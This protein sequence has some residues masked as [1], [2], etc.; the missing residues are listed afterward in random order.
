MATHRIAQNDQQEDREAWTQDATTQPVMA[1]PAFM[2]VVDR[3]V[4]ATPTRSYY[5]TRWDFVNNL[6]ERVEHVTHGRAGVIQRL[7]TYLLVGGFAALVNLTVFGVMLRLP[8]ATNEQVHN[9]IA[10]VIAAETSIMANFIPNDRITFSHLPGHSRSW[11]KRCT[12][13]H[14][15]SITGTILTF[16]IEYALTFAFRL[17]G[18][19]AETQALGAE[20]V[21]IIIV[22]FY[23][24][25]AHHLFTYR[26][27]H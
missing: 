3:P 9:I 8:L 23:N 19:G 17:P 13:F 5:L 12:R 25:T 18:V 21:A 27:A 22:L 20:A 1:A 10:Y 15:T 2:P 24:F 16:I 4:P 7:F 11:W 26:H 14:I 6:L